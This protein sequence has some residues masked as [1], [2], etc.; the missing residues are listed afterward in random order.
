MSDAVFSQRHARLGVAMLT[1]AVGVEFA[2]RQLIAVAVEPL[3][4]EF[5]ASDTEIGGLLAGFSAR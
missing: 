4:R 5:G 1:A 2:H 3:R